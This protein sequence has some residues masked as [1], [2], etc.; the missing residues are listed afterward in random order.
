MVASPPTYLSLLV[1]C[2]FSL[3]LFSPSIASSSANRAQQTIV[4]SSTKRASETIMHA[5]A[6]EVMEVFRVRVFNE[7]QK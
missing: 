4:P 5:P 6:R 2:F 1:L 7:P 3:L